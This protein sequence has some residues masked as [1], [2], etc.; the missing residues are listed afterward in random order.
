MSTQLPDI[1]AQQITQN[2]PPVSPAFQ[3]TAAPVQHAANTE[4]LLTERNPL[5]YDSPQNPSQFDLGDVFTKGLPLSVASGAYSLYNSTLGLVTGKADLGDD[6]KSYDS[7]WASYYSENQTAIDLTGNLAGLLIPGTGALKVLNLA[8]DADTALGSMAFVRTLGNIDRAAAVW[9]KEAVAAGINQATADTLISASWK[10]RGLAVASAAQDS[11]VL[12]TFAFATMNQSQMYDDYSLGKFTSDVLFGG[13]LGTIPGL[14]KGQR[15]VSTGINEAQSFLTAKSY[16]AGNYAGTPTWVRMH[17]LLADGEAAQDEA[18]AGQAKNKFLGLAKELVPNGQ[19][20]LQ[21]NLQPFLQQMNSGT[22]FRDFAGANKISVAEPL[23]TDLTTGLGIKNFLLNNNILAPIAAN[24]KGGGNLSQTVFHITEADAGQIK[25]LDV[26]GQS[27]FQ[28]QADAD[29][30]VAKLINPA[31]AKVQQIDVLQKHLYK[32]NIPEESVKTIG[33]TPDNRLIYAPRNENFQNASIFGTG[34][35]DFAQAI[36]DGK[37][38]AATPNYFVNL[39][40]GNRVENVVQTAG[41]KGIYLQDPKTFYL[42]KTVHK[43]DQFEGFFDHPDP[44]VSDGMFLLGL[45]QAENPETYFRTTKTQKELWNGGTANPNLK[46]PNWAVSDG[47]LIGMQGAYAQAAAKGETTIPIIEGGPSGVLKYKSVKDVADSIRSLKDTLFQ[48]GQKRGL[49]L[50]DLGVRLNINANKWVIGDKSDF[51]LYRDAKQAEAYASPINARVDLDTG[52]LPNREDYLASLD[53]SAIA[54]AQRVQV[55]GIQSPV[56]DDLLPHD[57]FVDGYKA[58]DFVPRTGLAGVVN[59]GGLS[60]PGSAASYMERVGALV[61]DATLKYKTANQQAILPSV[62]ALQKNLNAKFEFNNLVNLARSLPTG[63]SVVPDIKTIGGQKLTFGKIQNRETGEFI[64]D[65]RQN[66]LD[67]SVSPTVMKFHRDFDSINRDFITRANANAEARGETL[68]IDPNDLYYPPVD[69][70]NREFFAFVKGKD[71][72]VTSISAGSANDLR[73]QAEALKAQFGDGIDVIYKDDIKEYKKRFGDFDADQFFRSYSLDAAVRRTG[74][75]STLAPSTNDTTLQ[76]VLGFM[77]KSADNLVRGATSNYMAKQF[78]ELNF[79]GQQWSEA[80]GSKRGP[81][82]SLAFKADNPYQDYINTALNKSKLSSVPILESLNNSLNLTISKAF[83]EISKATDFTSDK[84]LDVDAGIRQIAKKYGIQFNYAQPEL[85][86]TINAT[87]TK[88]AASG[89]VSRFNGIMTK[90]TLSLD[91]MFHAVHGL[92]GAMLGAPELMNLARNLKDPQV[93]QQFRDLTGVQ[94]PGS[95]IQYP[96]LMKAVSKSIMKLFDPQDQ[97]LQGYV[98]RG[99]VQSDVLQYRETQLE[100]ADLLAKPPVTLPGKGLSAVNAG[101]T[102]AANFADKWT[103][104]PTNKFLQFI[105]ADVTH[106]LMDSMGLQSE[107]A[108]KDTV[109]NMIA[110]RV[111]GNYISGQRPIIFQGPLGHALGLFQTFM[112][113]AGQNLTRYIAEGDK[114]ALTTFA[115]MQSGLFGTQSNAL[116][117]AINYH[118][119][120][121]NANRSDLFSA[122]YSYGKVGDWLLYGVPSNVLNL[123]IYHRGELTP[124]NPTILPTALQDIPI[125]SAALKLGETIA[126]TAKVVGSGGGDSDTFLRAIAMNGLNRPLAGI[127]QLADGRVST[128]AGDTTS[129]QI[130]DWT[131]WTR[132]IGGKPFDEQKMLDGYYR[133]KYYEAYDIKQLQTLGTAI[134][135]KIAGGGEPSDDEVK[136][137]LNNYI[138]SGG[139]AR[140]FQRY[141]TQQVINANTDLGDRLYNKMANSPKFNEY[142]AVLAGTSIRNASG[143]DLGEPQLTQNLQVPP[144]QVPDNVNNS[145]TGVNQ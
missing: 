53:R 17:N 87:Y 132:V 14:I 42:D 82:A 93:I 32:P 52:G 1:S 122:A 117:N 4:F 39:L 112:F 13:V 76:E 128:N 103:T 33:V 48:E 130:R 67:L 2:I 113:A 94:I 45:K 70:R 23:D 96:S 111:N 145:A 98:Q 77:D 64:K 129:S 89:I 25:K 26:A 83:D 97:S 66:G 31:G 6:L 19:E 115:I 22:F 58:K 88:D 37:I 121:N 91:G 30:A 106:Q 40:T 49:T 73:N 116:F 78:E 133:Q 139:N 108:L 80:S 123:S 68:R 61:Q 63:Y 142:R 7:A 15:E 101:L 135:S 60:K 27:V 62:T 56:W 28:T 51:G 43:Y 71:G 95:N 34:A 124:I 118:I 35:K 55:I 59:F 137:F 16:I 86:K 57:T 18:I 46:A 10:A 138:G 21:R 24:V 20:G 90:L 81:L 107:T 69:V 8:K 36:K 44:A 99:V 109:A 104:E 5:S 74:R 92:S 114:A 12:N 47:N 125:V 9:K 143:S 50:D 41:D 141:W 120:K 84:P 11:L 140:N 136:S 3:S 127:A 29:A 102:K 65:Q 72:Q 100:L 119:G 131:A 54:E 105:S 110:R 144:Q 38:K 79:L 85:L 75:L 134:K 126:N